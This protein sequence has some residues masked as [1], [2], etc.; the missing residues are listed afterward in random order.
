M[1]SF[2]LYQAKFV[3]LKDDVGCWLKRNAD[4]RLFLSM[5]HIFG[6]LHIQARNVMRIARSIQHI[7]Q[8]RRNAMHANQSQGE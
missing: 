3:A 7:A 4:F 8:Q 6:I 2:Y 5:L 1:A